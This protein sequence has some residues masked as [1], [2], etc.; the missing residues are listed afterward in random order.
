MRFYRLRDKNTGLFSSGGT[1]PRWSKGGKVWQKGHLKNHLRQHIDYSEAIILGAKHNKIEWPKGPR[2][3]NPQYQEQLDQWYKF[4]RAE[5]T[6]RKE[7]EFHW[8]DYIPE[9]WEAVDV[10]TN[11]VIPVREFSRPGYKAQPQIVFSWR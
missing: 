2:K 1:S 5:Q 11:E 9:N 3:E 10:N 8:W 6:V 7:I 4:Y